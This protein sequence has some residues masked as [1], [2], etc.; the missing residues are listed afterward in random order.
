M[1][2]ENSKADDIIDIEPSIVEDVKAPNAEPAKSA[3]V[4]I[5]G[6]GTAL[7]LLSAAV[8]AWL[9]RDTLSNYFPTDQVQNLSSRLD[10]IET[11]N[12]DVAKRVDAVIALTDELKSK[13]G[14][15]VAAAEKSEKTSTALQGQAQDT[16]QQLADLKQGLDAAQSALT[17]VKSKIASGLPAGGSQT[18]DA[19][20]VARVDTLEKNFE[21]LKTA[22]ET[23]HQALAALSQTMVRL[24]S[25]VDAGQSFKEEV[26]GIKAALPSAEGLDVLA[27]EAEKGLPNATQLAARLD[28]LI[29]QMPKAETPKAVPDVSWFDRIGSLFSGLVT[30][31]TLGDSNWST[32]AQKAYAFAVSGD[33]VQAADSLS[34]GDSEIPPALQ[35][36]HDLAQR[37]INLEQAVGK[38]TIAIQREIAAKG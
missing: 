22:R 5:L 34:Q 37:R 38:S 7:A 2:D 19:N 6:G 17:D 27:V 11:T 26:D 28:A 20:L 23:A 4:R 24:K 10:V 35:Q 16:T 12:K 21:S 14:A 9:Y 8:G 13:L 18:S 3:M 36:W 25:K 15:A 33:L 1:T 31:K 32:L 30:V 29:A